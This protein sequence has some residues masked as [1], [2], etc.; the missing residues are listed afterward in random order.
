MSDHLR[1]QPLE[2]YRVLTKRENHDR[3]DYAKTSEEAEAI[4]ADED[5]IIEC[6]IYGIG[7]ARWSPAMREVGK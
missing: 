2:P 7:W 6:Y 1:L 3:L 5:G 4:A